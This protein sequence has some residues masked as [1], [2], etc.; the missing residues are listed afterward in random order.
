MKI[1]QVYKCYSI[2]FNY[3]LEFKKDITFENFEKY[4]NNTDKLATLIKGEGI[5]KI[6]T[7]IE[8]FKQSYKSEEPLRYIDY[9]EFSKYQEKLSEQKAKFIMPLGWG[10]AYP[11]I[12]YTTILLVSI[13]TSLSIPWMPFFILSAIVIRMVMLPLMIRQMVLIQRMAKVYNNNIDFSE[14]KTIILL[15]F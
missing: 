14:Y 1:R 5:E 9:N 6:K 15:Y 2:K 7:D 11:I 13:K 4:I 8:T 12:K 10:W 3:K